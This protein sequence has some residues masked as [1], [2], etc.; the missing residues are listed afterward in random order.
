MEK[1][2]ISAYDFCDKR[3]YTQSPEKITS[4]NFLLGTTLKREAKK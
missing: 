2:Q 3:P 4:S 1:F